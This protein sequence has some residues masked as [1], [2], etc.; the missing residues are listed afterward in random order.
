MIP[1][2]IGYKISTI[3]RIL[4]GACHARICQEQI[5]DNLKQTVINSV[6]CLNVTSQDSLENM[7][8]KFRQLE[9]AVMVDLYLTDIIAGATQMLSDVTQEDIDD[10]HATSKKIAPRLIPIRLDD[11]RA[12]DPKLYV[13][14]TGFNE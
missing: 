4:D 10:N 14:L 9:N 1:D 13:T 8:E 11:I 2:S 6:T 12:I 5:I 7:S 3:Q